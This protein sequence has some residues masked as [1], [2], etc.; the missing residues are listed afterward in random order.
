MSAGAGGKVKGSPASGLR[1]RRLFE[2][3][4]A[5]M[6][7]YCIRRIGPSDVDDAVADI[8]LVA[9]RRIDDMPTGDR[10]RLYL[11][12]IARNVVSVHR[13]SSRRRLRLVTKAQAVGSNPTAGTEAQVVVRH[14]ERMVLEALER[15]RPDDQEILRLRVW[16]DLSRHE[17]AEV[18]GVTP[19]AAD[20]R[21]NRA[22]K[23]LA[24]ALDEA[25]FGPQLSTGPQAVREGG[26][27]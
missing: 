23:R 26:A 14:E 9:W 18:L 21:Y 17:V 1:Y 7:L 10:A 2:E 27:A 13:R 19:P 25:G 11:Y 12:G 15:L 4:E 3:H 6:R 8:F 24:R 16:E 22:A 20:M 5:A